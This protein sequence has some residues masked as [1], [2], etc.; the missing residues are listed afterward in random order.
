MDANAFTLKSQEIISRAQQ[1]AL[2]AQHP[3][4]DTL[5]LLYAMLHVDDPVIP[6]L[7]GRMNVA[8]PTLKATVS[9]MMERLPKTEGAEAN[10]S[11]QGAQVL[12]RAVAISRK[13]GDDYVAS[14]RLLEALLA[15]K[16]TTAQL[17]KDAGVTA[18]GLKQAVETLRKG[19]DHDQFQR[20]GHLRRIGQICPQPQCSCARRQAR[21]SHRP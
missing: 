14:D 5:H 17:L 6:S 20:R 13:A 4:I 15:E 1:E 19:T 18:D 21:P 9:R 16:D 7:L 2:G 12:Q 10:W 11:R 8:V 3:T